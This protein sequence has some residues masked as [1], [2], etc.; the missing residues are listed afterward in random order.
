MAKGEKTKELWKNPKYREHMSNAHSGN[1]A[2][3]LFEWR[4]RVVV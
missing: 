2:I 3:N 1:L 4:E